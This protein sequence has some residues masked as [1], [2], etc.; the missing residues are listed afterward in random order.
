MEFDLAMIDSAEQLKH[1]DKLEINTRQQL[2]I[3][4]TASYT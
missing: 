1:L 3:E 4:K 2:H